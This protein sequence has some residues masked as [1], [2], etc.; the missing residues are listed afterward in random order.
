MLT[1]DQIDRYQEHG[2]LAVED[3]LPLDLIEQAR[4]V[5]DDFVFEQPVVDECEPGGAVGCVD[6]PP[7]RAR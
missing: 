3:V 7:R 6:E 4:A 2:F 1:Q 5:V